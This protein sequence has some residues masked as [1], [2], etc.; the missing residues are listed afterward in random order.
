VGILAILESEVLITLNPANIKYYEDK[1]YEIPKF[2]TKWGKISTPRGTTIIVKVKDL[3]QGSHAKVTKVCDD[4]GENIPNKKYADILNERLNG[5]GKDRCVKCAR[6]QVEMIKRLIIPYEKSLENYAKSNH[7]EYLIN[8]FSSRNNKTPLEVHYSSN[9]RYWWNCSDCGSE[10]DAKINNRTSNGCNCPFCTGQKVNNT[11]CLWT[12]NPDVAKLMTNPQNGYEI[13]SGSGLKVEF[14]CPDCGDIDEK[15]VKNVVTHGHK[16]LKCSD[17]FSIPEKFMINLLSQLKLLFKTQKIFNWSNNKRYD[18]YIPS[19]N[20]IIETHGEQHYLEGTFNHL[21]GKSLKEEQQNDKLKEHLAITNGIEKYIIIDCSKSELNFIKENISKSDLSIILNLSNID[22][23]K[24]FEYACGSLV[25]STCELWNNT[26]MS[27]GEIAKI[28]NLD[29]STIRR[30]LQQGTLIGMCKYDRNES[31]KRASKLIIQ[32]TKKRV[33]QLTKENE[34]LK[35]WESIAD[36]SR[37]LNTP[38]TGII[39]VCKGKMNFSSGFKWM[40]KEDYDRMLIK[41]N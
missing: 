16:C 40:Y 20:C 38:N 36:A 7:K 41:N 25:K 17:G 5:D 29:K 34:F 22:W 26:K 9:D 2:K 10:Y 14:T 28:L 13:T 6:T 32:S 39:M 8:E 4:C 18:F 27:T 35:E 19:L 1:G 31:A 15:S 30:Y 3:S 11:N 23:I 37:N 21:G 33:V 12:T 24:C